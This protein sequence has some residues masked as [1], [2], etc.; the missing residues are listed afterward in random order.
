MSGNQDAQARAKRLLDEAERLG[1]VEE[2]LFLE[3]LLLRAQG[4]EYP[5]VEKVLE[6]ALEKEHPDT[7]LILEVM[8]PFAVA[9]YELGK[10]RG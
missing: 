7:P 6:K 8:V 1:W 4:G 9:R 3:R 10:A 2:A 5:A